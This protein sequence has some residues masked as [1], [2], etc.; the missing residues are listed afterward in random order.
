MQSQ[1]N[2]HSPP[3]S[4]TSLGVCDSA[5]GILAQFSYPFQVCA[6]GKSLIAGARPGK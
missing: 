6:L 4:E 3:K 1:G 5:R 2:W